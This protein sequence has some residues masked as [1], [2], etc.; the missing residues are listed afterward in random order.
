LFTTSLAAVFVKIGSGEITV[1]SVSPKAFVAYW[2]LSMAC[3]Y[4]AREKSSAIPTQ[5]ERVRARQGTE[6]SVF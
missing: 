1:P 2:K 6:N 3:T 5:V 4:G